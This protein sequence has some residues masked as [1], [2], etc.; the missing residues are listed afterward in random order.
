[1]DDIKKAYRKL[2]L[3]YHPDKNPGDKTA[4]EK[5]KEATEAYEILG[6]EQKRQTYDQFGFAGV[7]GMG[8]SNPQDF[9]RTF[10]GFEDI[11]GDFGSF[12]GFGSGIF[13]SLF[14]GGGRRASRDGPEQ[15]GN[16]Q[17]NVSV[18]FQ[19]SIYGVKKEI[20]YNRNETCPS[21]KGTGAAGGAARKTCPTC[22][23]VGQVRHSSGFFSVASTCPSCRGAGS[24]VE[25]PC[26]DCG[27]RGFQTKRRNLI[28]TI[29]AGVE[30]GRRLVVQGQGNAGP[31]GGPSGNLYVFVSVASHEYFERQ[32]DDLFCA[33]PIS[34]TQAALGSEIQVTT[35][36]NK[37]IKVKVPPGTQNGKMLRIR[38]EG[39]PHG[40]RKG[41]L[42]IKFM[43]QV[44]A[45]LSRRGRELL[46]ELS[47][48]EGENAAPRLVPLAELA[49]QQ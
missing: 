24:I 31:N 44:P 49:E 26:K 23:G 5:F 39:V 4:E 11:F 19:E 12:G 42:Y 18:T 14:G 34:I 1:M 6:D 21:C 48:V 13:E 20:A 22:R 10:R 32:D 41:S 16:I 17:G 43:V 3:Q 40:G 9:A 29:P 7:E 38:D 27:G 28:I 37:T 8:A 36:D 46:E 25:H 33:V 15:G 47:R 2:A 30:N 45:K 35:L